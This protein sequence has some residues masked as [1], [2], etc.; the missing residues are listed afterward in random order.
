MNY[1][2]IFQ[3]M[4][5]KD[6]FQEEYIDLTVFVSQDPYMSPNPERK[7]IIKDKFDEDETEINKS[8]AEIG[9]VY[10]ESIGY[11]MLYSNYKQHNILLLWDRM[12]HCFALYMNKILI[13]NSVCYYWCEVPLQG[14]VKMKK[15]FI[16]YEKTIKK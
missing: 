15:Y 8:L 9:F 6:I 14:A 1:K 13:D 4:N 3:A 5:Y 2:D 7:K 12:N 10:R 11:S 16:E